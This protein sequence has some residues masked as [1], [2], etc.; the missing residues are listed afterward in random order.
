MLKAQ[1]G[2]IFEFD[3]TLQSDVY[4][5]AAPRGWSLLVTYL[6]LFILLFGHIWHGAR[7]IFRDVFWY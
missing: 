2:E 4:S 5:V 6:L 7:T 1:L 3:P